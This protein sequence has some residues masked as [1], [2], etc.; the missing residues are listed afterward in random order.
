MQRVGLDLGEQNK[1][2]Y[3]VE[4]DIYLPSTRTCRQAP[5]I[6]MLNENVWKSIQNN[7][8]RPCRLEGLFHFC[9]ALRLNRAID[10]LPVCLSKDDT[11]CFNDNLTYQKLFYTYNGPCTKVHYHIQAKFDHPIEPSE[12]ILHLTFDPHRTIVREEYLIYDMVAV[13]SAIG[14]TMGL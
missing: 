14:G 2:T 4:K 9:H 7:C 13:V 8:A 5:F 10:K 6:K 12:A 3:A 1:I 11:K